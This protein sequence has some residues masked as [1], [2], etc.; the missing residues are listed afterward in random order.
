MQQASKWNNFQ[1]TKIWISIPLSK[2]QKPVIDVVIRLRPALCWLTGPCKLQIVNLSLE[3]IPSK[4]PS[5]WFT[6]PKDSVFAMWRRHDLCGQHVGIAGWDQDLKTQIKIELTLVI[7]FQIEFTVANRHIWWLNFKIE[8]QLSL[9][10]ASHRPKIPWFSWLLASFWSGCSR[11]QSPTP[12][13]WLV[14]PQ[15]EE[16]IFWNSKIYPVNIEVIVIRIVPGSFF[17]WCLFWLWDCQRLLC[18]R[19]PMD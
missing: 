6:P 8:R 12:Q 14:Q 2:F 19:R 13:Y 10:A 17:L 18:W 11:R 15:G 7:K 16:A 9:K 1:A 3:F 4:L 5:S